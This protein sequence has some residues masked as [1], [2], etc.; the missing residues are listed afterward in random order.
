[1]AESHRDPAVFDDPERFDPDRFAQDYSRTAFSPFGS[2]RHA[3]NGVPLAMEITRAFLEELSEACDWSIAA[4]GTREREF[5]HWSH[6]R[7]GSRMRLVMAARTPAGPAL[8]AS[9]TGRGQSAPAA[10]GRLP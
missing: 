2:G 1:V 10:A 9:G 5:R 8:T 3:C 6:W 4:D 7:P